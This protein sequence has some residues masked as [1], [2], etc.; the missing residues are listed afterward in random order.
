MKLIFDAIWS[1]VELRNASLLTTSREPPSTS[2]TTS[3][4][5]PGATDEPGAAE[6][7]EGGVTSETAAEE[8]P[9][10][11]EDAAGP[12]KPPAG[13][14]KPHARA[15]RKLDLGSEEL[16][17]GLVDGDE[18]L[19]D[20]LEQQL[21]GVQE[22]SPS[23]SV[24][25]QREVSERLLESR[26]YLTNIFPLNYR[27]EVLE[28]IFSL[29][30]LRSEHIRQKSASADQ[31]FTNSNATGVP[32]S[33]MS[34]FVSFLKSR[35]E[36]LVDERLA[37][38]L[39]EMLLD[40]IRELRAAK[41][42]QSQQTDASSGEPSILPSS[43][44]R[45]SIAESALKSRTTKLEQCVNEARWRLQMVSPKQ[46]VISGSG[47]LGKFEGG[48][49]TGY[50]VGGS[51]YSSSETEGSIPG[52]SEESEG[53][54]EEGEGGG[55]E[56]A[57][58][59]QLRLKHKRPSLLSRA[60][61]GSGSISSL[62]SSARAESVTRSGS[63]RSRSSS[64]HRRSVGAGPGGGGGGGGKASPI[65]TN[66]GHT[67]GHT[68]PPLVLSSTQPAPRPVSFAGLHAQST[69]KPKKAVSKQNSLSSLAS[70][71]SD[72]GNRTSSTSLAALSA[73]RRPRPL[74]EDSGD[75]ADVEERS[76]SLST[77]RPRKKRLHSREALTRRKRRTH[78]H[79]FP[80]HP[81]G[82]SGGAAS[83]RRNDDI[84][85]WMLASAD[86]LL[87][88]CLRHSN[89]MRAS[90]VLKILNVDGQLGETLIRFSEQ[91]ADVSQ[92]LTQQS[93]PHSSSSTPR[94]R[95]SPA[96]ISASSSRSH[97]THLSH[98]NTPPRTSSG[99]NLTP[100]LTAS[101]TA[102]HHAPSPNM[103]L[104]VA[105]MNARS[106]FDPLQC[107]HQLLAPSSIQQV[108]FSGD[109]KLEAMVRESEPLQ[110]LANH[111]PSLVMLDLACTNKIS[112]QIATKLLEAAMDR[113]QGDISGS[114][115]SH[116]PLVLLKFMSDVSSHFTQDSPARSFRQAQSL[117]PP[118]HNSP[119]A[120]LTNSTHI[121]TPAAVYQVRLFQ[122]LYREARENLEA[123]MDASSSE[124]LTTSSKS[125]DVFSQLLQ[126][127]SPEGKSGSPTSPLRQH[128]PA[129]GSILDE[130]IRALQSL[131]PKHALPGKTTPLSE[132]AAA[133]GGSVQQPSGGVR[134]E[135]SYLW[136]FGRYMSRLMDLL[137][138]C[139]GIKPSSEL[140]RGGGREGG[141]ERGGGEGEGWRRGRGVEGR[142]R[143]GGEGEGWRGGR[144]VEGR[145]RGGGEGEGWRGGRGVEGRERDGGERGEGGREGGGGEG[146]GGVERG[147]EGGRER[148]GGE[149]GRGWR[150]GRE[151]EGWGEEGGWREGG[152]GERG[153]GRGRGWRE[154]GG[155]EEI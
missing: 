14:E 133:G 149:G 134:T 13:G 68:P 146:E 121:L 152:R 89:Y 35:H 153:G 33:D 74:D 85:C 15:A 84:I 119:H 19:A 97:S 62:S 34:T 125:P 57:V 151:G 36:F 86:S 118:A 155:G 145:E 4:P 63:V 98:S 115:D 69:P 31:L 76:P 32:K 111:V 55:S 128:T 73:S 26:S 75:A 109:P 101:V 150:E 148:G 51:V 110:R 18:D 117:V 79:T 30:F 3:R 9:L 38:E 94:V 132:A 8:K 43:T 102:E 136:H 140:G 137:V 41:Y 131:Q 12:K 77:K 99:T 59:K 107:V 24:R 10:P 135:L 92:Q 42:A 16:K 21:E 72:S 122:D 141:R 100:A 53:E 112:G 56:P 116:G 83:G 142:E 47:G 66:I 105:I 27:L 124:L 48:D 143:G 120:L 114:P 6:K 40:C 87:R 37:L 20:S 28:N 49:H 17:S 78:S 147:R 129:N 1:S 23:M 25:Y 67:P 65:F 71:P 44:V 64:T 70:R 154:G 80:K 96:S 130:L 123:E 108:L 81:P 22:S 54:G 58:G 144:G 46:G 103:N 127:T 11:T 82:S 45:C 61:D 126:L 91:Y 104:Q 60:D 106:S 88:M 113:L 90:E 95:R 7:A 138:K 2:T 29:M 50:G 5:V 52:A 39:L 139:L 93:S